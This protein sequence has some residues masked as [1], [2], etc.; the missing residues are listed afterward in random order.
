MSSLRIDDVLARTLPACDVG[1]VKVMILGKIITG[2]G[3]KLSIFNWLKRETGISDMTGIGTSSLKVQDFYR[4]LGSIPYYQRSID[5]KW[6]RYHHT[7][8]RMYLY[9]ITGT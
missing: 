2:D 1:M 6:F 7:D 4:V 3:S 5:S 9:D 8:S